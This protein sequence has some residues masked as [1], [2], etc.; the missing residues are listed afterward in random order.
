MGKGNIISEAAVF[1]LNYLLLNYLYI[2]WSA[3]LNV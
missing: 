2:L 3:V 1:F